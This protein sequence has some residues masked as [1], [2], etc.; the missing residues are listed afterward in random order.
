MEEEKEQKVKEKLSYYG[1]EIKRDVGN[2]VKWLFPLQG[3]PVVLRAHRGQG[4]DRSA[5]LLFR[6]RAGVLQLRH[7][8]LAGSGGVDGGISPGSAGASGE[9]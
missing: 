6:D 5:H 3:S 8:L 2:L 1:Q 9:I 4:L 7:G